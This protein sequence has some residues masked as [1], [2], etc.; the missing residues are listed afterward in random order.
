MGRVIEPDAEMVVDA[1]TLLHDQR[2]GVRLVGAET[3]VA[4]EAHSSGRRGAPG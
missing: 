1:D 4:G 3:L 2:S